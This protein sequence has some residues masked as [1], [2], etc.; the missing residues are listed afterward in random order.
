MPSYAPVKAYGRLQ[1]LLAQINN[2]SSAQP[3]FPHCKESQ[4][5]EQTAEIGNF[6]AAIRRK[7]NK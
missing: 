6:I 7:G 3:Y 1:L 2:L 4:Q 5:T